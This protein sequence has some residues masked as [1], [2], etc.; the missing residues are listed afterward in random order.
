M[1]TSFSPH[2]YPPSPK[3]TMEAPHM[4]AKIFVPPS[5]RG[6]KLVPEGDTLHPTHG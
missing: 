1:N 2:M 3:L 6:T 5:F 4:G